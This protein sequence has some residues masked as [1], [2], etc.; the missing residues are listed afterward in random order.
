MFAGVVV[1][2][3][4]QS[5]VATENQSQATLEVG[6]ISGALQRD[7]AL[8]L[9]LRDNSALGQQCHAVIYIPVV[10]ASQ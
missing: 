8:Q 3:L 7:L 10:I 5:V 2:F 4:S 6:V 1:G 9:T